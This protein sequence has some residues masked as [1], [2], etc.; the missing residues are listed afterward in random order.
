MQFNDV[1]KFLSDTPGV[2][3]LSRSEK[4]EVAGNEV[5]VIRERVGIDENYKAK[6]VGQS[7]DIRI[8]LRSVE[9]ALQKAFEHSG[10]RYRV[11]TAREESPGWTVIIGETIGR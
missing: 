5:P 9:Y 2:D 3:E 11:I 4:S 8:K 1:V 6:S 7:A 10:K